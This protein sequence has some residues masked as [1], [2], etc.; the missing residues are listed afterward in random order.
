MNAIAKPPSAQT[1]IEQQR[2]IAEVQASMMIARANPRDEIAAADR[3]QNAFTRPK[4]AEGALYTYSRGGTE[5]SGLSIRSAE[6]MARYWGNL[7]YGIR[8]LEQRE[9]ES[10]MQAYCW[11][12]ETN[13]RSEK[14]FTVPHQR[15]GKGKR[16][17]ESRDI[18]ENNANQGARRLR[19]CILAVIPGDIQE[20]AEEQAQ[21]TLNANADTSPEGVKKLLK[22]FEKFGVSREQIETRIQRRIDSIRP[23][24][25]I[26]LRKIYTSLADSMSAAAD[27][28]PPT[29]TGQTGQTGTALGDIRARARQTESQPAGAPE[30]ASETAP[31]GVSGLA[32]EPAA[33]PE[34]D[35]PPAD[36]GLSEKPDSPPD[37]ELADW[38]AVLSECASVDELEQLATQIPPELA[39]ALSELIDLRKKALQ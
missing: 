2:A 38:H 1:A 30:N 23:A 25:V 13:V 28:F 10:V 34:Q 21:A 39:P 17:T 37:P 29:P 32:K 24:Q 12:M 11:D 26:A 35:P 22:A 33:T 14:V 16:L 20:S 19:A 27:W 6:T 31:G 4:L 8:E 18:Y 15:D 36:G 7:A 9:G 3:I 5:I